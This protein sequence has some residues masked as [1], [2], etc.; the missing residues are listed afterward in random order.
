[1]I[2]WEKVQ[3]ILTCEHRLT[4]SCG[5]WKARASCRTAPFSI[6]KNGEYSTDKKNIH[7]VNK[8]ETTWKHFASLIELNI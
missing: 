5:S 1:M 2:K 8:D 7:A 3:G 6:P 4:S